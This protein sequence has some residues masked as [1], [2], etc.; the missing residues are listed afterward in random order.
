MTTNKEQEKAVEWEEPLR[1]VRAETVRFLDLGSGQQETMVVEDILKMELVRSEMF[2]GLYAIVTMQC[3]KTFCVTVPCH[4]AI[5]EGWAAVQADYHPAMGRRIDKRED[6]PEI[7]TTAH[8]VKALKT[9]AKSAQAS[10]RRC[11]QQ[12][13]NDI[14]PELEGRPS[15]PK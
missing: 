1:V 14:W 2:S 11:L 4:R 3:G 13:L 8:L 9:A 7:G 6:V 5:A 12:T 10:G 15:P